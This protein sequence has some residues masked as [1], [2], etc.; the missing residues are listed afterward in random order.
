M[1]QSPEMKGW[2][3][4]LLWEGLPFL[5]LLSVLGFISAVNWDYESKLITPRQGAPDWT[6]VYMGPLLLAIAVG[7]ATTASVILFIV[8]L[9]RPRSGSFWYM[10]ISLTLV[11]VQ[12]IF[13]AMFM[14]IL[15]PA[16]ITMMEQMRDAKR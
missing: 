14:V 5:M 10:S 16:G 6:G 15:G 3:S 1:D 12:L 11:A 9:T 2:K 4:Y 8:R 7:L 13:P